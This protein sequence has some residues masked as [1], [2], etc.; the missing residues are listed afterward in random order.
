MK[1]A[2]PAIL[3]ADERLT[4]SQSYN[5]VDRLISSNIL[6]MVYVRNNTYKKFASVLQ[7]KQH[8]TDTILSRKKMLIVFGLQ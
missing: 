2:Q 4:E 8:S 5:P 3:Q 6:E 1:K 7:L